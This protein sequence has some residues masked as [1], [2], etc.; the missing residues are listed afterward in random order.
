MSYCCCSDYV[1]I[2]CWNYCDD[3]DTTFDAIQAGAHTVEVYIVNGA[4]QGIALGTLAIADPL[5]VPGGALNENGPH[6]MRI[7]QPDG[8]Y[9]Q[10]AT[11]IDC[12]RLTT[13]VHITLGDV[14]T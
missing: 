7:K 9:Y 8:T 3:I 10:F 12:L 14:I 11:G 4:V 6:D 1:N 5:V 13:Q 2:G